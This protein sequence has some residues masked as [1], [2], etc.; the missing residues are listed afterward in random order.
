[1]P[2]EGLPSGRRGPAFQ[3]PRA[4]VTAVV[5]SL[6]ALS[7]CA[8][9]VRPGETAL[10][11]AGPSAQGSSQ[12]G[13]P[14]QG[15]SLAGSAT[16]CWSATPGP[17]G[18]ALFVDVTAESGLE[19][20][21][22]GLRVHAVAAGDVNDDGWVDL[23]VGSFA[24]RAVGEYAQR[25]APGPAPDRLLLGGPA[26]FRVDANF[27]A[28]HGR[29]SGAAFADLDGDSDLDLVVGRQP[30]EAERGRAPSV[31]LRNDGGKFTEAGVLDAAR[32]AR[33]IGVVDVDA[34]GLL[35]LF[36]V[37]DRFSGGSSVLYRNEGGLR[38]ADATARVGLPTDVHGLGV[39]VTDLDG[40][41]RGDLF[42]AGSNRLFVADDDGFR[43]ETSLVFAW[44]TY[45]DED[46]VAGVAVGDL[47][48][49]GRPDLVLGQH[50]NSTIDFGRRVPVRVYLN[51]GPADGRRVTFTDITEQAG[52]TGL[53]TKAPHV[54]IVDL[55]A[56]GWPDIVATA[57]TADGLAPMVFRNT[58]RTGPTGAGGVRF[59]AVE[60][61]GDPR[62]W[63]TGATF[64]ADHDG[65]LEVLL[66]EWEPARASPLLRVTRSAGHWLTVDVGPAGTAGLGAV[67][68][69]YEAG[70]LGDPGRL[71]GVRE[72]TASTGYGAGAEPV[73]RFGLGTVDRVD[74]EVSP[75]GAEAITVTGLG[76][77]RLVR[78]G[79]P[80]PG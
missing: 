35:D 13:P 59:E 31:V 48:R 30:R 37:E 70:H 41:G 68:R 58:G 10:T 16:V 33:S 40:D 4:R 32:G 57:A 55:D 69:V 74:V 62:Y 56:D 15:S 61:A 60:D 1:M 9:G 66:G 36:L 27:P 47:D 26:G 78:V 17:S 38:F 11:Q 73:A 44:E 43:E 51:D 71:L 52:I 8:G 24:D 75:R 65:A 67:V 79:A 34:D 76:V 80:C 6:L 14:A 20:A 19:A 63:V 77:D 39:S 7:A 72:I 64:D 53:P 42:V 22:T 50:Y 21:L 23:F 25:G 49:D 46:D 29:T 2:A 3:A 5:V 28:V 45:G 12:A 54:E 18:A